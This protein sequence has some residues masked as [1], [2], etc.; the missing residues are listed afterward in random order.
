MA[1]NKKAPATTAGAFFIYRSP[2]VNTSVIPAKA[3]IQK[4]SHRAK[5][6]SPY[7]ARTYNGTCA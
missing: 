3:G 2:E 1:A 6:K 4:S 7:A 5:F